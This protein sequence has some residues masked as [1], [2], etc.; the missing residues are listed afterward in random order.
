MNSELQ[1]KFDSLPF[2]RRTKDKEHS[3]N[4]QGPEFSKALTTT[5]TQLRR[6]WIC[7]WNDI[8]A[9]WLL[10]MSPGWQL[11]SISETA[12]QSKLAVASENIDQSD[13]ALPSACAG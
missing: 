3:H 1:I 12:E 11:L 9:P 10:L 4:E 2:S 5:G 7:S 6:A 13:D 8:E